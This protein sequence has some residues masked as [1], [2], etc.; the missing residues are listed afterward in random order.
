MPGK[1][2]RPG[3]VNAE[4]RRR[5]QDGE[6]FVLPITA[7]IETGNHIA[8][9]SGNRRAAAER[10]ANLMDAAA[11]N[12]EPFVLH[13]TAWDAGFLDDLCAGD[14]T[15]QPFVDLAGNGQLGA[16]E[17]AILDRFGAVH[18]APS[19]PADVSDTFRGPLGDPLTKSMPPTTL[20]C[21]QGDR[22]VESARRW[23]PAA[24]R[25]GVGRGG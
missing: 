16:G 7:L 22:G 14:S 19:D 18:I 6:G 2:Q 4:F 25:V 20:G 11:R 5:V 13:Q 1:S 23:R 10:L 9:A 24:G 15:G 12:R 21:L 8:Q 17:V 3:E